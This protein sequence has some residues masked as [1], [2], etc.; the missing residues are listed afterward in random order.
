MRLTTRGKIVVA[1]AWVGWFL[2]SLWL[3][4]S[5]PCIGATPC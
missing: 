5:L 1:A 3:C 2:L 4:M